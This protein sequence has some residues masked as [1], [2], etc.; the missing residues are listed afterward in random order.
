MYSAIHPGSYVINLADLMDGFGNLLHH[1]SASLVICAL[2]TG[3]IEPTRHV[4]DPILVLV[5]QHWFVLLKYRYARTF[6]AIELFLEVWFQWSIV[7][8]WIVSHQHT[9]GLQMQPR[10]NFR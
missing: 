7:S 9:R 2:L 5:V 3:V 8:Q 6:V 10:I 4:V 1:S